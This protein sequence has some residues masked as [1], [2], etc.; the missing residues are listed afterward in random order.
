LNGLGWGGQVVVVATDLP[1]L[2]QSF[3]AWL[4]ARPGPRSVVPVAAGRAQ[5]LCARYSPGD[6][7]VAA[8]LVAEGA[9]SMHDLLDSIDAETVSEQD[10]AQG[11]DGLE[12]LLDVDTPDDLQIV[13]RRTAEQAR[14]DHPVTLR[15]PGL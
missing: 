9:R 7:L 5:P 12:L 11:G 14:L 3:L 6:L 8:A 15:G 1:L 10:W 4:A 2:T 13:L